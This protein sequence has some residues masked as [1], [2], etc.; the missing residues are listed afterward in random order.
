MTSYRLIERARSGSM[1]NTHAEEF[2]LGSPPT[3]TKTRPYNSAGSKFQTLVKALRLTALVSLI[4]RL[5]GHRT[6]EAPKVAMYKHRG[7]AFFRSAIHVIPVGAA[8]AIIFLNIH[9]FYI[10]GELTGA[11]G[12]DTQKLAGLNFAAKLHE[13]LMLASITA[14]LFAYI[15]QEITFGD[16]LPFGALFAGLEFDNISLL[17]SQEFLGILYCNWDR[18]QKKGTLVGLLVFCT[19]LGVSVGPS[20]N[21]LMKPRLSDWPSGG[22]IFYLNSTKNQLYPLL[23]DNSTLIAHCSQDTGDL[24]C[25]HGGWEIIEKSYCPFLR[26]LAPGGTVPV[27]LLVDGRYAQR[28]MFNVIRLPNDETLPLLLT[29][30]YTMASV[31]LAALS[32]SVERIGWRYNTAAQL[33]PSHKRFWSRNE[34]KYTVR[35]PQPAVFTRCQQET[36]NHTLIVADSEYMKLSSP[37]LQSFKLKTAASISA[38]TSA[39]FMLHNNDTLAQV[40]RSALTLGNPPSLIWYDDLESLNSTNSTLQVVA[41]FPANS[42]NAVDTTYTCSIDSIWILDASIQASREVYKIAHGHTVSLGDKGTINTD[43]PRIFMTADW[44]SNLNPETSTGGN[45]STP[46]IRMASTAGLYNSSSSPDPGFNEVIVESIITLMV[47]NGLGRASYNIDMA[48]MEKEPESQFFK[49]LVSKTALGWGGHAYDIDP[50]QLSNVTTLVAQVTVNGYA[51]SHKGLVQCVAIAVLGVYCL[52]A[53]THFFYSGLTG[54]TS[55]SWDSAPEVVAL[56]M[57]SQPS[58]K[59]ENTGAG[60]QTV[61]LYEEKV[62]IKARDDHLEIVF[63][64]TGFGSE[65]IEANKPCR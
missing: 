10:G 15:R 57:S 23:F 17:W 38:I 59:L 6:K 24:S 43:Y 56:A 1:I 39:S 51:Y 28:D 30:A 33:G 47:V 26:T 55:N 36:W 44:A 21:L 3:T 50:G 34:A 5:C 25:P 49:E 32:D 31:P 41:V 13:L 63:Q 52:F 19:L 54:W 65:T 29:N 12:Q 45:S 42:S 64:D 4:T 22:T 37:M 58:K 7:Q 8:I 46:F 62:Q 14:G 35:S 60:I 53:L 27:S 2:L 16:G 40:V 20:T 11:S 61:E 48:G 18:K 9:Q